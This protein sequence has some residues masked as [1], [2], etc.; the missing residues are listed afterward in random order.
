MAFRFSQKDVEA[1]FDH[2]LKAIG[3]RRAVDYKDVGGYRLDYNPVY[4][5]Y[6][7][8]IIFNKNGAVSHPFG[9]RLKAADLI[10]HMSFAAEAIAQKRGKR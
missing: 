4:G 9:S 7:I 2:F 3:K 10:S 1:R 8:E 5:G 6:S